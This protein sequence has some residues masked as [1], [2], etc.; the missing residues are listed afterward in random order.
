VTTSDDQS[1]P[2]SGSRW[3]PSADETVAMP[4]E[5]PA[6]TPAR[7]VRRGR[8]RAAVAGAAV[9]LFAVGGVGGFAIGAAAGN[10]DDA[11]QTGVVQDPDGD[12]DGFHGGPR[13]GGRPVPP[14]FQGDDGTDDDGDGTT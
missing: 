9:A 11:T 12:G 7:P 10:D 4:T 2:H 5:P 3:E 8:R 13:D 14:D 6:A 1:T